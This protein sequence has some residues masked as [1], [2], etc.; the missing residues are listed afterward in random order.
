MTWLQF[1]IMLLEMSRG[2]MHV[3][4]VSVVSAATRGEGLK[5]QAQHPPHSRR[6]GRDAANLGF[7]TVLVFLQTTSFRQLW[8]A[9]LLCGSDHKLW[10][11]R[12][13]P[14]RQAPQAPGHPSRLKATQEPHSFQP[15]LNVGSHPLP[16]FSR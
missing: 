2:R 9:V 16:F 12:A 7:G 14:Y 13:I 5:K 1:P 3:A 6:L 15:S 8:G 11:E 4:A 10:S